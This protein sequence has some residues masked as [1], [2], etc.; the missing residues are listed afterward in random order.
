M[1]PTLLSTEPPPAADDAQRAETFRRRFRERDREVW[2]RL[3][4]EEH[5]RI[6][7]STCA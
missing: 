3:V 5:G 6:F 2:E 1:I 4:R 7:N